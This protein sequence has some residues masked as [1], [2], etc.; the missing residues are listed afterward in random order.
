MRD[1]I[2]DISN[3]RRLRNAAHTLL[4]R[5]RGT[6]GIGMVSGAV[7]LGKTTATR[8]ICIVEDAVWVEALPDW[9]PRWMLAD[10]AGEL[11]AERAPQTERNFRMIVGALRERRRAIFIDEADRLVKRMHLAE[12]LRA[13]HDA[14]DAPLIL[15]GMAALPKAIRAIPQIESRVAHWV[16]FQPCDFRDARAMADQL[17]E[18]VLDDDLVRHLH[19]ESGG[20]ARSIR[21]GLERIENYARRR[22]KKALTLDDLPDGFDLIYARRDHKAPAAEAAIPRVAAARANEAETG[23]REAS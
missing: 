15:I 9:T 13:I 10:I 21:I 11:G 23:L 19:Q 2:A 4:H 18:I 16:E 5:S 17:C 3:V 12:T 14:T 7:G 6:P 8:H 22:A 1:A 20:S